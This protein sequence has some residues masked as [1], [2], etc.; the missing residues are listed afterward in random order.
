MIAAEFRATAV[1]QIAGDAGVKRVRQGF[2]KGVR[3]CL[4]IIERH[5]KRYEFHRVSSGPPDPYKLTRRSQNLVNNYLIYPKSAAEIERQLWGAYGSDW[6]YAAVHEY[7]SV[8]RGIPARPG[9]QY[10]LDA[11]QN[12]IDKIIG[13]EIERS[14]DRGSNATA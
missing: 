2:G 10:T 14:I 1:K 12:E 7:G 13:V 11:K 4:S 5:H 3:K 6:P 8:A 9:V